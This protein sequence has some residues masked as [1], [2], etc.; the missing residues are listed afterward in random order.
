MIN[1]FNTHGNSHKCI[2]ENFML[3]CKQWTCDGNAKVGKRGNK[4]P[5]PLQYHIS[6]QKM[7]I[8]ALQR[9]L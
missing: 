8:F 9:L 7:I 4:L 2:A 1:Q 5:Y 3:K 6:W